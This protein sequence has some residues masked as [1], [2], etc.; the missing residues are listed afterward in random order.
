MSPTAKKAPD[1]LF[2]TADAPG[3]TVL[4]RR[5]RSRDFNELIGQE[6]IATTLKQAVTS[7]RTAHAY[8]FFGTRGVGKTSR[9]R[10]FAKAL[11]ATPN[12][13][14]HKE[15]ADAILRGDDLDV[16]EIDA[17]SN[18]GVNEARDLIANAALMPTRSPYKL[19]IID[20]V[21][22][23]TKDAFNTLLKTMEEPPP[24]VKFI[25]CTTDPHKVPA[26]IQ[27]RCQRF[28][29][30]PVPTPVIARHL[31]AILEKE[32]I[33]ADSDVVAQVARLGN[34]SV[35]DAL[36]LLDRLLA[37]GEK[38]LTIA[39]L[40]QTLGLPEQEVVVSLVNAIA[41][42]NAAASLKA[43]D[44][45]M[46]RG[47]SVEQALESM[48]DHLRLLLL[49]A[50]CGPET[51]LLDVPDETRNVVIAQADKFTAPAIVHMIAMCDAV[52][53]SVRGS[54]VDRAIF[55]AAIVR[56]AMADH[57]T[58]VPALMSGE[59]KPSGS[60]VAP[61]ALPASSRVAAAPVQKKKPD[62]D[63]SK[64]DQPE[65]PVSS[66]PVQLAEMKPAATAVANGSA[67]PW[68]VI[69]AAA[70]KSTFANW[71]ADLEFKGA[72]DRTIRLAVSQHGAPRARMLKARLDAF[73]AFVRQVTGRPYM[74]DLD[75]STAAPAPAT[76]MSD[77]EREAARKVPAVALAIDLFEAS[78]VGVQSGA[79]SS[80]RN[81]P[82]AS[83]VET[84]PAHSQ[85]DLES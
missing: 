74:V 71:M 8:L 9:A 58:A 46:A 5:Y 4:A 43:A 68:P 60:C 48:V 42:G 57:F 81:A 67:D 16:I 6:H 26:T 69:T 45:I 13:S 41:S 14:Q 27:S 17:A 35:R 34:G 1:A 7:G 37:M 56:M 11:N 24:H 85:G 15:I 63:L 52:T 72:D 44:E 12:L 22:A 66:P 80:P 62:D 51:T 40:D 65:D 78:L 77:A 59:V 73:T 38:K 28:D 19:Y 79:P 64:W 54:S 76:S 50:T 32:G 49:A 53:R 21:H 3:Y 70:A 18:R 29:F 31:A 61:A 23:L 30:R 39:L 82:T 55:D 47:A 2:G 33:A 25:L 20:E 84:L 10:I 83:S 75:I 36:S